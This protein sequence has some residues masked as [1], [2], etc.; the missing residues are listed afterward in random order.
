MLVCLSSFLPC[1]AAVAIREVRKPDL[2]LYVAA[3]MV[4]FTPLQPPSLP[5]LWQEGTYWVGVRI[6]GLIPFGRQAIRISFPQGE[7]SFQLRDAG[8]SALIRKWDHL[9]T[10]KEGQG[11]CINED[12]IDVS[13]GILTPFVWAFARIF[14]AHRQR[15]WRK[16][17]RGGFHYGDA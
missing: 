5:R 17:A 2:L 8:S 16:L 7:E 4:T 6:F 13:A 9:I 10:I 11:G 3:P 15:R 14:Y 1:K 12:R